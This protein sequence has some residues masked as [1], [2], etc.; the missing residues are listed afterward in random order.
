VRL[1]RRDALAAL[2]AAGAGS[3]AGCAALD[4]ADETTEDGPALDPAVVETTVAVATTV[5]PSEV[6]ET[7]AFVERYLE[8][9]VRAD[10]A[11]AEALAEAV[12]LLEAYART[13]YDEPFA[14][15]DRSTRREALAEMGVDT[16]EPDP[17]GTDP[18]RVRHLVVNDLLY[19]LYA[20]PTGARLAGLENPPGHPGGIESYREGPG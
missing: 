6:D 11:R 12:D 15:L 9:R 4:G 16:A 10:P 7:E 13:I 14:A 3:T 8:G 19:A 1:S 5:Y 2:A 18:E 20:S 17:E